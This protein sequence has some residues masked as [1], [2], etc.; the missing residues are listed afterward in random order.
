M[1]KPTETLLSVREF[2]VEEG[3]TSMAVRLEKD[4]MGGSLYY[5]ASLHLEEQG[6]GHFCFETD[7]LEEMEAVAAAIETQA[8]WLR[9]ACRSALDA[10]RIA[11]FEEVIP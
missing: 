1:D 4:D 9:W 8:M 10:D 2:I 11:D 7:D 5:S 6:H 3:L